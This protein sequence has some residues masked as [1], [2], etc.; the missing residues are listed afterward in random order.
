MHKACHHGHAHIVHLLISNKINIDKGSNV[1]TDDMNGLT[2]LHEA[3]ANGHLDI[4]QFLLEKGA[5][6]N[7]LSL[8]KRLE[9]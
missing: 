7:A 4:I 8:K 1:N 2:P 3:C 6:V 5:D 9:V